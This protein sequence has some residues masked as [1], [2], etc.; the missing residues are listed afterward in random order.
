MPSKL[1]CLSF[2][3]LA[4]AGASACAQQLTF[5]Q[6]SKASKTYF[7]DTAEFPM[8]MGL[9][10]SAVDSNGKMRKHKTGRFDYDFHGYNPRSEKADLYMRGSRSG[11]KAGASAGLAVLLPVSVLF[12]NAEA[13]YRLTAKDGNAPDLLSATL[14]PVETCLPAKW[15]VENYLL[16]Q[17]CGLWELDVTRNGLELRHYH[18]ET[19]GLPAQ[20]KI[21]YLGPA[22]VNRLY[23]DADFQQV[24]I[25]SDPKPFLVPKRVLVT[26]ETDRGKLLIA[27]DFTPKPPKK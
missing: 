6:L 22:T 12:N 5:E 1:R 11:L 25:P 24:Q 21:D 16:N 19:H 14:I 13:G 4:I 2:A 26:V 15:S 17:S 8:R 3:L 9:D 7:R 23:V 20:G 10:F 18:F 27:G